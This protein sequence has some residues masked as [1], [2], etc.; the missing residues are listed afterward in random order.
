MPLSSSSAG[1]N[2]WSPRNPRRLQKMCTSQKAREED[3]APQIEGALELRR[4]AHHQQ[5]L[6][7]AE[8]LAGQQLVARDGAHVG[9]AAG[10]VVDVA[11]RRV[12]LA[13]LGEERGERRNQFL[14]RAQVVQV[15][16]A[17][18]GEPGV[19]LGEPLRFGLVDL[20]QAGGDQETRRQGEQELAAAPGGALSADT[21]PCRRRAQR[22]CCG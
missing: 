6:Q 14:A 10:E 2:I 15:E 4:P 1:R 12:A 5:R 11:R 20:V 13:A 3:A 9:E 18:G 21:A 17:L 22:I 8:L 16:Q 19:D 7:L